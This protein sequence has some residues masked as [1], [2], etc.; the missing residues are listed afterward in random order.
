MK[1]KNK[2]SYKKIYNSAKLDMEI[3]KSICEVMAV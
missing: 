1:K 3:A 2:T